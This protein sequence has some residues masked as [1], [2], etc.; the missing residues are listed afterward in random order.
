[1]FAKCANPD[2]DTPFDYRSGRFFRFHRRP[3]EG[4][5]AANTHSVQHYWL[6]KACS[7]TSTLEASGDG[8]VIKQRQ[9]TPT[10]QSLRTIVAA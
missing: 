5:V 9:R 8:V 1:M 3:P 4:Q 6:C 2:C 10:G 7:E